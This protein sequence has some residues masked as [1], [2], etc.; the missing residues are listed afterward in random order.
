M[1]KSLIPFG[2]EGAEVRV[3][4]KSDGE[5]GF[6][7]SDVA[8]VLGYRDAPNMTRM[9]DKSE[10]WTQVVDTP[11]GGQRATI[12]SEPGLYCCILKSRRRS[13]KTFGRWVT[14]TVLPSIRKRG[15]YIDIDQRLSNR[16]PEEISQGLFAIANEVRR[17][18]PNFANKFSAVMDDCVFVQ[19]SAGQH[20]SLDGTRDEVAYHKEMDKRGLPGI[21]VDE[22]DPI[23]VAFDWR[24]DHRVDDR[25]VARLYALLEPHCRGYRSG[26]PGIKPFSGTDGYGG[27]EII[28]GFRST[29]KARELASTL[30]RVSRQFLVEQGLAS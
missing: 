24:V 12:I 11:G 5:V 8:R 27:F 16:T 7:A 10:K 25:I 18:L 2:F 30:A 21:T 4:Q 13:A 19:Q 6:V 22:S 28:A 15:F 1:A 3:I 9:L 17:S 29:Q 20:S 23:T 14:H 26:L